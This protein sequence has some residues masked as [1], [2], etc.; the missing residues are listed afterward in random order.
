MFVSGIAIRGLSA[1]VAES[2]ITTEVRQDDQDPESSI[3]KVTVKGQAAMAIPRGTLVDLMFN[4]SEQAELGETIVLKNSAS[5]MSTDDPPQPIDPV[6]GNDGEL[7]ID[8]T[9]IVFACFF[10]MH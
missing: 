1:E 9:A 5:A 2:E 6:S 10:F 4:I 7:V 8:E 3:L